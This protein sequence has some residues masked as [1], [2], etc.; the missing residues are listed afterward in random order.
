MNWELYH[1]ANK[2]QLF[3]FYRIPIFLFDVISFNIFGELLNGFEN[4]WTLSVKFTLEVTEQ[5]WKRFHLS[6]F[7]MTLIKCADKIQSK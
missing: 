2:N 5:Q 1:G 3:E 7:G 4:L 6:Q